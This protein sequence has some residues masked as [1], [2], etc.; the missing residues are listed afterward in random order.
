MAVYVFKINSVMSK[1]T[2]LFNLLIMLVLTSCSSL[3]YSPSLGLTGK[4][5]KEKQIDISGG[6]GMLPETQPHIARTA[7][8]G[9]FFKIGYGFSDNFN[10]NLNVWSAFKN[11]NLSS[12]R[13]Y[14][15]HSRIVFKD[16][17]KSRFEIIPRTAVLIDGNSINGYGCAL[18]FV[19]VNNITDKLFFYIGA[20]P[21]AGTQKFSK[22]KDAN[23][24]MIYPSGFGAIGHFAFGYT[25]L[26]K[27]RVVAEVNPIFEF[28]RYDDKESYLLTPSLTVGYVIH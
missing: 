12:R 25:F 21:A 14:S 1:I 27:F 8:E 13:G 2:I 15:L 28:N 7:T 10:L 23:Q 11:G 19:Y 9:A 22:I 20:G 3:V 24:H 4:K 17:V 26:S 16:S 5:L 6:A 18:A